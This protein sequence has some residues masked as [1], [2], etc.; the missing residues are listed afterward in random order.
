MHE[1]SSDHDIIPAAYRYA[2][3]SGLNTYIGVARGEAWGP[4]PP[5]PPKGV[6]KICTAVLAVQ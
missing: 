2:V 1:A 6:E 4:S 3:R 5:P